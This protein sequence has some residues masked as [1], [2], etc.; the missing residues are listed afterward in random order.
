MTSEENEI[1]KQVREYLIDEGILR[2][3]IPDSENKI[4]FGFR[5]IFILNFLEDFLSSLLI[6]M[7]YN[8]FIKVGN[9]F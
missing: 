9:F 5:F 3:Q 2:T 6:D 7:D 8:I 4:E 1:K